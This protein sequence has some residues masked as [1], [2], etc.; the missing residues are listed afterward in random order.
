L[1][2]ELRRQG[3]ESVTAVEAAR[4]LDAVGLLADRRGGLPLRNLLRAKKISGGR[5]EPD[6]KY[7]KW[8]IHRL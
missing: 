1:Q 7:G 3:L 5:Q 8:H 4:W 2:G 6:Q